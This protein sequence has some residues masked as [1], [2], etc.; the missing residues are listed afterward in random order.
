[1]H[2]IRPEIFYLCSVLNNI[3]YISSLCMIL[4]VLATGVIA[5]FCFGAKI[6][7]EHDVVYFERLL[8]KML[9]PLIIS[10]AAAILIPDKKV[11]Y[12]MMAA[13]I[14]TYENIDLVADTIE[15]KFDHII[16]KMHEMQES[17]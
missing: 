12:Q 13:D 9:I 17:E 8:R 5:L 2:I 4:L 10:A 16:D 3:S 1:M 15:D 6:N 11:M 14:A 7:H